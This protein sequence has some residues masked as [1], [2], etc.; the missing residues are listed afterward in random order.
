VRP[1]R[2]QLASIASATARSWTMSTSNGSATSSQAT[3]RRRVRRPQ[4]AP[5]HLGPSRTS[6]AQPRLQAAPRTAP[7]RSPWTSLGSGRRAPQPQRR[8]LRRHGCRRATAP[9]CPRASSGISP[10]PRTRHR[11]P[12]RFRSAPA[13]RTRTTQSAGAT[14]AAATAW[15]RSRRPRSGASCLRAPKRRPYPAA[16][17]IAATPA[18]LCGRAAPTARGLQ[19][20]EE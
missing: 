10:R 9:P 3:R 2:A 20:R 19:N 4:A 14:F 11:R 16:S 8:D 1:R 5:G 12:P 15:S 13:P 18:V 17:T 6:P 7:V